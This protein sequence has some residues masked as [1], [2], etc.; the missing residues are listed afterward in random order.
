MILE[1]IFYFVVVEEALQMYIVRDVTCLDD[2]VDQSKGLQSF[3]YVSEYRCC[4]FQILPC[5]ISYNRC[6]NF[7]VHF[8]AKLIQIFLVFVKNSLVLIFYHAS[9]N[10]L[11]PVLDVVD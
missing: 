2:E 7:A 11:A 8:I 5:C 9:C 3:H 4:E 10:A 1:G 6:L